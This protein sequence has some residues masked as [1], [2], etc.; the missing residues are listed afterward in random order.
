MP[1]KTTKPAKAFSKHYHLGLGFHG[2]HRINYLEWGDTK[3]FNRQETLFC[4]HG[5]T[6]NARDFDYFA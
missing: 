5:I 3:K 4:V 2:F 6:R 1:H